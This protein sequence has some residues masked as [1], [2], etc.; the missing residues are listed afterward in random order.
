LFSFLWAS[1]ASS[2]P[3]GCVTPFD[4]PCSIDAWCVEKRNVP[5]G[6]QGRGPWLVGIYHVFGD[7]LA[8]PDDPNLGKAE[9]ALS[10]YRA[11]AE[12]NEALTK[13]DPKDANAGRNLA[14][15]YRRVGMMLLSD[16]PAEAYQY[17]RKALALS[18]ELSAPDTLNI[19]HRSSVADALLGIGQALHKLGKREESLQNLGPAL[20]LQ[21][22]IEVVAPERIFLLPTTSRAYME[23]GNV[24]LDH[25]E[26]TRAL[27]NYREGLASAER[28]LQ[29]APSTM[30]WTEPTSWRRQVAAT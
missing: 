4:T 29:R 19:H 9:E 18:S 23:I 26:Y 7:L 8:A 10:N 22:S 2:L 6:Y 14:G 5:Y 24:L 11:A 12:L 27:D 20:E 28:S 25:G 30:H 13:A 21:K 16:K 15:S 3:V 1:R 17:Y